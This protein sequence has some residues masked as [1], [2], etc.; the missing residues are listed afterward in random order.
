MSASQASPVIEQLH[1]RVR[2]TPHNIPNFS[3]FFIK[4]NRVD[5]LKPIAK[6]N[7]YSNKRAITGLQ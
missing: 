3:P 6:L 5:T 4:T 2:C 1:A 7:A